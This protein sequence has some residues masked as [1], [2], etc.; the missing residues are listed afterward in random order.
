MRSPELNRLLDVLRTSNIMISSVATDVFGVSGMAMI[1]AL[2]SDDEKMSNNIESIANLA[3]QKLRRKISQLID[4]L[5]G[6]LDKHQKQLIAEILEHFKF[7]SFTNCQIKRMIDERC[8][9]YQ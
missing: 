6:H 7:L 3:E 2:I 5:N 9:L 8:L 4:A 1:N